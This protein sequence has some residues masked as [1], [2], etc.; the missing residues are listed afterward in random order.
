MT[1]ALLAA[2]MALLLWPAPGRADVRVRRLVASA[3][4]AGGA[5]PAAVG[6]AAAGPAPARSAT[7]RR[8][9]V[10][11]R[12][13]GLLGAGVAG[14]AAFAWRGVPVGIA[15]G[16]TGA[17]VSAS[18][19]RALLRREALAAGR[20][21]SAA[22]RMLRAELD[23]GSRAEAALLAAASVAG[24]HRAAFEAGARAVRDGTDI[25]VAMPRPRELELIAQAW[26]LAGRT[27]A[28]LADVL[29]RVD[30]DVRAR[31][32]HARAVASSLAGP[33]SSAALLAALPVLG[34]AL[35]TAMGT[36]PLA[37]LFDT[38]G[39]R[40]LLCAGALLDAGG[41]LWTARLVSSAERA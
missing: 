9:S 2:G 8:A 6:S 20:D 31:R 18:A 15:A 19:A 12:V 30:D 3:R 4:L 16:V 32:A 36:H 37:I 11:P 21:L 34:I 33:R 5:A 13:A 39:G 24:A 29:A 25:V 7:L 22:L 41:V 35:G 28:P 17:V 14:L 10:R 1:L 23:V 40:L 26:A 27:G 38:T